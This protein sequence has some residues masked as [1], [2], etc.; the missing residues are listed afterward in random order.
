MSK[1]HEGWPR[2]SPSA[3]LPIRQPIEPIGPIDFS[4]SAAAQPIE[5]IEPIDFEPIEPI[6]FEPIGPIEPIGPKVDRKWPRGI[7]TEMVTKIVPVRAVDLSIGS[8]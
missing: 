3:D 6:D 1:H 5:P 8:F 7:N 4:R 2:Y